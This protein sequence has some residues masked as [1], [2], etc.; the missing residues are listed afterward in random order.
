MLRLPAGFS[1]VGWAII[2]ARPFEEIFGWTTSYGRPY[3]DNQTKL[4][5]TPQTPET[6]SFK[7]ITYQGLPTNPN[8]VSTERYVYIGESPYVRS[9]HEHS[10]I[11]LVDL[12]ARL[13]DS[14]LE[15]YQ[16]D[17]K[18]YNTALGEATSKQPA[19]IP[20]HAWNPSGAT[21]RS[22]NDEGWKHY[23]NEL[24]TFEDKPSTPERLFIKYCGE[25]PAF[26]FLLRTSYCTS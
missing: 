5:P 14:C 8:S 17:L 1:P 21:P 23:Y 11:R 6:L 12:V 10:Y 7:V 26:Y 4:A 9:V 24:L 20:F 18:A 13:G 25:H 16:A 22:V 15:Y 2:E 3:V 19:T